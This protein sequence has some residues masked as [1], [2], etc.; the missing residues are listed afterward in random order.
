[1]ETNQQQADNTIPEKSKPLLTPH[2]LVQRHMENPDEP[3][4]DEDINNLDISN[5][6][7]PDKK[8]EA[9]EDAELLK[10]YNNDNLYNSAG[11]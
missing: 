11:F 9:D 4:T 6:L 8:I 10:K 1:M 2:E 7:P 3:I 5:Q